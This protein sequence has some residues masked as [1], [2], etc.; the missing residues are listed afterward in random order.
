MEYAHD[1]TEYG[2]YRVRTKA[3][4]EVLLDQEKNISLRTG[5]EESSAR[6]PNGDQT[7]NL[8]YSLDLIWKF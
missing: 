4:W 1:V 7:K 5:M 3:A 6:V 8:G 2:R